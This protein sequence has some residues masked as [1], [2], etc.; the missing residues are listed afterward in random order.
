MN[1][2]KCCTRD[3]MRKCS[4]LSFTI[5]L[6][7]AKAQLLNIWLSRRQKRSGKNGQTS[8]QDC[9]VL[10]AWAGSNCVSPPRQRDRCNPSSEHG[11]SPRPKNETWV[12]ECHPR[13]GRGTAVRGFSRVLYSCGSS[14]S[15][16][17]AYIDRTAPVGRY[18]REKGNIG[19]ICFELD[20]AQP[21]W[22]KT[23]FNNN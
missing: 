21:P 15:A 16:L 23:P 22:Q 2:N 18:S 12:S 17:I 6:S 3:T 1:K 19:L 10:C 5:C 13:P 8:R 20:A 9:A 7:K 14:D 11:Q 4:E